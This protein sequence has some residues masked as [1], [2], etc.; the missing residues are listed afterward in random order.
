MIAY[1]LD[2]D[3][4]SLWAVGHS[5]VVTKVDAQPAGTVGMTV[6][7]QLTGWLTAL[8]KATANDVRRSTPG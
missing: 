3:I 2:K 1:L 5:I 7:E 4:L 8:S 6:E